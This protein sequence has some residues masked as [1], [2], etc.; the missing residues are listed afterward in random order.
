[1]YLY[2]YRS[3]CLLLSLSHCYFQTN[4]KERVHAQLLSWNHQQK[5]VG[6]KQ[7]QFS[8][9]P[10][11]EKR[12]QLREVMHL[13]RMHKIARTKNKQLC[14]ELWHAAHYHRPLPVEI[15]AITCCSSGSRANRQPQ[16]DGLHLRWPSVRTIMIRVSSIIGSIF[17]L[18]NGQFKPPQGNPHLVVNRRPRWEWSRHS[19]KRQCSA[20]TTTIRRVEGS[21]EITSK[22]R[23]QVAKVQRRL[24]GVSEPAANG[25]IT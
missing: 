24:S 19:H 6:K 8:K 21:T 25:G 15:K 10:M 22:S 3:C 11:Y 9:L 17:R 20:T 7:L 1:M 5:R 4:W 18:A 13:K 2:Y 16:C 14:C 23:C 12:K